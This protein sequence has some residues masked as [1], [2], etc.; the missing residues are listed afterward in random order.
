MRS[1]TLAGMTK[2]LAD[3]RVVL[4]LASV[5]VLISWGQSWSRAVS[6]WKVKNSPATWYGPYE[7]M[8]VDFMHN[9]Q[10]ARFWVQGHDPYREDFQDPIGRKLCYPPVVVVCFAWCS[11]FAVKKAIAVW[12]LTLAG[13]AALG[14]VAAWRTR[15]ELGLAP[16]PVLV[17]VAAVVTSAPVAYAM[18]RGNYDLL[19][20]PLLLAMTWGLRRT[21]WRADAVV[22]AALGLAVCLKVYPGLLGV[23]LLFLGRRRAVGLTVAATVAFLAVRFQDLPIFVQNLRDLAGQMHEHVHKNYVLAATHSITYTWQPLWLDSRLAFLAKV[24]GSAVAV[25]LVGSLLGW[26]GW[27]LRRCPRPDGVLLPVLLWVT[28]AATFVPRVAND[29][30]L[31]FLPMAALAVWDR[32]DAVWVHVALG[33]LCVFT[34][35]LAFGVSQ[36][37]VFG[38]K[39]V[40]LVAV[41]AA[42]V[43]R[44]RERSAE[45]TVPA[46]VLSHAAVAS[47]RLVPTTEC[48]HVE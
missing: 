17:A 29:Y 34:Q 4:S 41:A 14:A 7:F 37:V 5:V 9:Y 10:A 36:S 15:R 48:C 8:S 13:L 25:G 26:V 6:K 11:L 32:R 16:V 38:A 35:P 19:I 20:V 23:V 45:P 44:I 12:T 3:W 28:A 24:P 40:A 1:A 2:A 30:S 46:V 18:E 47:P 42:I 33:F 27:H 43:Q 22:G 31:F 21:G 39:V